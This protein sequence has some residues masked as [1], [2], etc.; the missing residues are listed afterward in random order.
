MSHRGHRHV[1]NFRV[2]PPCKEDD[3]IIHHWISGH[4]EHGRKHL[5][6]SHDCSHRLTNLHPAVQELNDLIEDDPQINMYFHLM[7][8]QVSLKHRKDMPVK[9]HCDMIIAINTVMT[10]P[11]KFDNT[12]LMGFPINAIL[13]WPMATE[14]GF[15]A[16]NDERV[17]RCFKRILD[18]WGKF[19][20]TPES[21]KYLNEGPGGWFSPP[22]LERM[23]GFEQ[24][25]VCD[26]S[27]Q[28]WGFKSWDDFFVRKFRTG[29][30]PIEDADDDNII[31]NACESG[32]YNLVQGS[33]LT[34][35][36]HFWAKG[37]PYSL[38]HIL[39]NDP[40][41]PEIYKRFVGGTLYQAFLSAANYHRWHSPV[42]GTIVRSWKIPGT[43]YAEAPYIHNDDS[44][45]NESQG[46]LAEVATRSVTLIQADNPA[47]GLMAF[48]A[49]GMAEVSTCDVTVRDGQRVRKGEELGMF[50]FGGSTHLLIFGPHVNIDFC[51]FGDNK[52]NVNAS[53][54]KINSRIAKLK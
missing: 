49:I 54:I 42:N 50:H 27:Q 1:H 43:Y 36:A 13:N 26:R 30:R 32:P 23:S 38:R 19:L 37:Q 16:F 46:F 4:I 8:E 12:G 3:E 34:E 29:A 20:T 18:E 15:A 7:F 41:E 14:A 45:P 10:E 47:I 28:H 35:V 44:A 53:V 2:G 22:A 39:K 9:N 31:N 5:G 40:V 6:V 48:V 25:F 33:A 11:S 24:T 21:C 51:Y 52:P 17:N